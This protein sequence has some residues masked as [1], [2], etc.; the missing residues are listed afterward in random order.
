MK[1]LHPLYLWN[2]NFVMRFSPTGRGAQ[3]HYLRCLRCR[4]FKPRPQIYKM[5]AYRPDV[6]LGSHD[7]NE[8]SANFQR[9]PPFLRSSKTVGLV[10][11]SACIYMIATKIQRLYLCFGCQTTQMDWSKHSRV[12]RWVSN[13]RWPSVTGSGY[14]IMYVSACIRDSNEIPTI[15]LC[16]R[17]H[18]TRMDWS[19]HC[20]VSVE[21]AIKYGGLKPEVVISQLVYMI[22]TKFQRIYIWCWRQAS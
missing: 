13:Q 9:K 8:M 21:W 17:C 18:A 7:T 16:F 15:Y 4:M 3:A 19:K 20:R 22:A 14:G 11:T 2:W 12:S 6:K 10:R 5:A 1:T